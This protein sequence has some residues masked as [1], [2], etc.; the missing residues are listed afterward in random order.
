MIIF[1]TGITDGQYVPPPA[2]AANHQHLNINT[3]ITITGEQYR[4]QP[5]LESLWSSYSWCCTSPRQHWTCSEGGKIYLCIVYLRFKPIDYLVDGA[6]K[7]IIFE[8][9]SPYPPP[10]FQAG[11]RICIPD[12][13]KTFPLS[14]LLSSLPLYHCHG[15][16]HHHRRHHCKPTVG[17]G[18]LRNCS[19]RSRSLFCF[20]F[21]TTSTPIAN[22]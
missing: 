18:M 17:K 20:L 12:P 6:L 1:I 21:I 13:A 5:P 2:L 19:L 7:E 8:I 14:L 16:H 10:C 15:H 22:M 11:A 3:I 9:K 4:S